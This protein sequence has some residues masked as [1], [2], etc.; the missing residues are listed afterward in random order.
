MGGG[1]AD[2]ILRQNEYAGTERPERGWRERRYGA[3]WKGRPGEW[4]SPVP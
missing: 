3:S 2:F 1:G 4:A